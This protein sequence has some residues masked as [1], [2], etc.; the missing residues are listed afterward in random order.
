MLD[1]DILS[2]LSWLSVSSERNINQRMGYISILY[3]CK[4]VNERF[5]SKRGETTAVDIKVGA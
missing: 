4:L 1:L 2:I 5:K 3:G